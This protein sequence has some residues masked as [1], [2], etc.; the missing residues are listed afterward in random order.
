MICI[1]KI[2]TLVSIKFSLHNFSWAKDKRLPLFRLPPFEVYCDAVSR[3]LEVDLLAAVNADGKDSCDYG[4]HSVGCLYT[5]STSRNDVVNG[6]QIVGSRLE[7]GD[8]IGAL[9][10][11]GNMWT[12]FAG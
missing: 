9:R 3:L 12:D 8:I 4:R 6:I 2:I 5:D 11:A 1:G 10:D 7:Y